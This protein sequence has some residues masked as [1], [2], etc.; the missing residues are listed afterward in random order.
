[1]NKKTLSVKKKKILS[2]TAI[3]VTIAVLILLTIFVGGP[4][5]Q[6]VKEPDKFRQWVDSLGVWSYLAFMGMVILQVIVAFIPGEPFEI[7]AGYAFGPVMGTIL[8]IV[9]STIGS[10]LVFF[11]VRKFGVKLVEVFFS[12]DKINNLKFLKDAKNRD[13]LFLIIFIIPGTPKDLLSYFAGLL[14]I[15]PVS[16]LLICS[17]GRIPSIITSTIGG[18][19]LQGQDYLTAIIVFVVTLLISVGGILIYNKILKKHSDKGE[20]IVE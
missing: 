10:M 8:C 16:W 7:V 2:I 18:D 19:L 14:S 9:A 5:I 12:I 6:F 17:L 20:N 3:V 13:L 11:L 15:S 1:M 4:L